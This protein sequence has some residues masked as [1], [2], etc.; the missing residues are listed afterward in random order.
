MAELSAKNAGTV[1]LGD[2]PVNRLGL[3]TN[4]ISD[5]DESR[6]VLKRAIELGINFI[7]TAARY[8]LS[9]QIIGETLAS[10]SHGVVV[11]TKGG[12][13][14]NN[15]P[16]RLQASIDTSLRLIKLEQLPLW[17]LHR[18][19]LSVPVE[20][21]IRFLKQQM[22]AGKIKNIGLSE[23][24]IEQIERA[25]KIVPIVSVQNHYN[26]EE[27]RHEA[28]VDYCTKE[29]IA[30]LPYYPLGSGMVAADSKLKQIAEKYNATPIQIAI[31]WLLKRSPI[32][33][34]I[35]GTLNIEHLE[36]NA[37]A[38]QIQLSDEDFNSL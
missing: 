37:A 16:S 29:K 1:K 26:L 3:G 22:Q 5:N 28:V 11:S 21:T 17:H 36:S 20:D 8:G 13:S 23:V 38:A 4:R 15:D 25:C 18:V 7:D 35:P 32:M 24:S 14:D 27:R 30:F 33:L 10:Y 34:P 12:W 9:E 19:D 6:A 31:A 2:L